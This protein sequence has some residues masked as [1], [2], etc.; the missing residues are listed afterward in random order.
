MYG[1]RY[2]IMYTL[3]LLIHMKYHITELCWLFQIIC[4]RTL[5]TSLNY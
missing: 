2:Y 5:F 3:S 4:L 1:K